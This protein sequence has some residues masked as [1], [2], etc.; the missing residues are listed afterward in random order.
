MNRLARWAPLGLAL[1]G[2]SG[3]GAAA[4]QLVETD[5]KHTDAETHFKDVEARGHAGVEP[6]IDGAKDAPF[7]V[8]TGGIVLTADGHR[9][10]PGFVVMKE[11]RILNVGGGDPGP[12]EG[13]KVLDVSG[14]YVTPGLIDTHSHLGVYPN[15]GARAHRDGNE[16]TAP[17]TG[18]VWAEHSFWPPGPG[19]GRL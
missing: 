6:V 5:G 14:H 15:P 8:L 2:L 19:P 16:A 3:C 9:Y 1:I 13:A 10:E 18:G 7:V 17:A 12:V 4:S 11:G